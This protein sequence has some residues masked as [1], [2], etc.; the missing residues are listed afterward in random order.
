[1]TSSNIKAAMALGLR[2]IVWATIAESSAPI[3]LVHLRHKA[4]DRLHWLLEGSRLPMN[5]QP[6]LN[7]IVS[8]PANTTASTQHVASG[9]LLEGAAGCS[10]HWPPTPLPQTFQFAITCPMGPDH[11]MEGPD[12]VFLPLPNNRG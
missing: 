10:F 5:A 11:H 4:L 9:G 8:N 2:I 3:V 6:K 12:R 1:M 7:L